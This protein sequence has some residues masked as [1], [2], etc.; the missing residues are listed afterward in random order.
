M[1]LLIF[2]FSYSIFS[3]RELGEPVFSSDA[4]TRS[5]GGLYHFYLPK[6][7][8]IELSI[9]QEIINTN[10]KAK[11]FDFRLP[12][13]RYI[14]PLPKNIIIDGSISELLNLNFD[15]QSD[16][17]KLGQ[18]S[19]QYRIKG[20]GSV[21]L[22]KVCVGWWS[23][24]FSSEVGYSYIFGSSSEEWII[25]FGSITD[26]YDTL[27]LNFSGNGWTFSSNVNLWKIN[28]NTCFFSGS[29]LML[30][31]KLPREIIGSIIL[32]ITENI[33]IG[34]GIDYWNWDEPMKKNSFGA[35]FNYRNIFYRC[36]YYNNN[37][38]YDNIKEKVLS[39]GLGF[40]FKS[41]CIIDVSFEFGERS[42]NDIFEKI[43]RA[44]ITL[45]GQEEL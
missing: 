6:S 8:T 11:N 15:I 35:E 25:D 14:L 24:F 42:N 7:L 1:F 16:W 41:L 18:D 13:F 17:K 12:N 38:Y 26:R 20:R 10:G 9:L 27:I 3:C 28:L 45:Q 44:C 36:G 33:T 4:R 30:D 37:W 34:S 40:P 31:K 39:F 23:K 32:N 22:A 29:N 21:S 19:L 5:M 2:L 43:Y